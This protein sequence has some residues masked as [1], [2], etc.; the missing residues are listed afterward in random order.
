M[1]EL[2]LVP[3]GP[4]GVDKGVRTDGIRDSLCVAP[5]ADRLS[6]LGHLIL[7]AAAVDLPPADRLDVA[8]FGSAKEAWWGLGASDRYLWDHL[9]EHLRDAGRGTEAER[10]AC[11]LRWVGA[12][13]ER[14]GPAAPAG[15]IALA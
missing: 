10:I 9:I 3:A 13:L 2:V 5:G 6:A 12:R 7:K 14:F 1:G 8:V 15:D 11:D 4:A